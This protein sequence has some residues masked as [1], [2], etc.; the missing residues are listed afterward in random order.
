LKSL[1]L[2][3]GKEET[4]RNVSPVVNLEQVVSIENT[5]LDEEVQANGI[6]ITLNHEVVDLFNRTIDT[7]TLPPLRH[8]QVEGVVLLH[9][10]SVLFNNLLRLK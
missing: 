8:T 1:Q 4:T 3:L 5:I 7:I 2:L 10:L 9:P 6:S